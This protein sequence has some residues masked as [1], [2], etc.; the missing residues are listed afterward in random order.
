MPDIKDLIADSF[1]DNT[2]LKLKE[3]L[4]E[5]PLRLA[6]QLH[7]THTFCLTSIHFNYVHRGRDM[8]TL[9][10]MILNGIT[11]S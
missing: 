10:K 7:S 4:E 3:E 11:M 6:Y 2:L 8:G 5:S 9:S 1:L